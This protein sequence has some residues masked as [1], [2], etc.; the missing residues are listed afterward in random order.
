MEVEAPGAVGHGVGA[1]DH[2]EPVEAAAAAAAASNALAET[3]AR[4]PVLCLTRGGARAACTG[5]CSRVRAGREDM[6]M[7]GSQV[8]IV[9]DVG[10]DGGPFLGPHITAVQQ[11]AVL[12]HL[13]NQTPPQ[14]ETQPN[15]L[16]AFNRNA[17]NK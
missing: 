3:Q 12:F 2:H 13:N 8:I 11:H 5:A 14:K 4:V 16:E 17:K 1:H 10:G 7:T 15:I 9:S 6:R